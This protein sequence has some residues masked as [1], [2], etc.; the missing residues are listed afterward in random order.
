MKPSIHLVRIGG[1]DIG[2]HY[3]WI[4]I[5]ALITYSLADGFFPRFFETWTNFEYWFSAVISVL[6]LFVALLAHELAHS[7]VSRARGIPV[8]DITLFLLGGVSNITKK[9][10]SAKTEF[11]IAIVGPLTSAVIGVVFLGI[12]AAIAPDRMED[13]TPVQGIILYLGYVNIL[14]AVFNLVPGFPLDGGRVL[15]SVAWSFSGSERTATNI[16]SWS[17]Q[18]VGWLLIIYGLFMFL[19]GELLGGLWMAFIGWFLQGAANSGRMQFEM[20]RLLGGVPVS[21]VMELGPITVQPDMPV[22]EL[23]R[24]VFVRQGR[25]A[26][27]V[28]SDGEL[29]GIVTL[30]DVHKPGVGAMESLRTSQVMTAPPITV[31]TPDADVDEALNLMVR[32]DLNQVP[33]IAGGQLVGL[34]SREGIMRYFDSALR[35]DSSRSQP[36]SLSSGV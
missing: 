14:L 30:T 3:S 1:I 10:E 27:P 21:E 4:F 26:A 36:G 23:V 11:L 8:R 15:K 20:D 31:A 5:A 6:L 7:F 33:V 25:R 29:V 12:W 28:M 9:P 17:G 2:I 16:A 18:V 13:A 35:R 24:D 32:N 19:S 22:R 34:L